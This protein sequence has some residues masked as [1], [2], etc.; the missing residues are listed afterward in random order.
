MQVYPQQN[1]PSYSQLYPQQYPQYAQQAVI[2]PSQT[3]LYSPTSV[4]SPDSPVRG[5][6][7]YTD[8]SRPVM[9]FYNSLNDNKEFRGTM[10]K[11]YYYKLLDKWLSM[12]MTD[13]LGYMRIE[14][15]KA[16]LIKSLSEYKP[17]TS[18][19]LKSI[20]K[21]ADYIGEHIVTKKRMYKYLSDFTRRHHIEWVNIPEHEKDIKKEL[22]YAIGKKLKSLVKNKST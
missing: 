2:D 4:L 16:V 19:D 1:P 13:V 20:E 15:D 10:V 21:K 12:F 6:V 3:I 9:G 22:H 17:T 14:G 8:Y 5:V 18:D 7:N 11:H